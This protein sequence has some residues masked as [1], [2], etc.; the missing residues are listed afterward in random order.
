MNER[1][2]MDPETA[3]E[4]LKAVKVWLTTLFVDAN[5]S[6]AVIYHSVD[7]AIQIAVEA[8]DEKIG[9]VA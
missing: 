8:L 1:T 9:G 6:D 2:K 5:E 3:I 7:E 4:V